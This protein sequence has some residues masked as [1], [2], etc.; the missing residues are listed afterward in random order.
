MTAIPERLVVYV[1]EQLDLPAT[2]FAQYGEREK[3]PYDHLEEICRQY[4]YRLCSQSDVMLL[5][6]YLLPF[7]ME[8]EEALPKD[9][10]KAYVFW[11][12]AAMVWIRQD[13]LIAPPILTL[14]RLVWRVQRIA[15]RRIYRRLT[16]ALSP[17]QKQALDDLLIVDATKAN[18]TPLAW[19]RIPAKKPSPESMYHLLERITYLSDLQLPAP[20]DNVHLGRFRQLAKRRRLCRRLFVD[21]ATEHSRWLNLKN[22][23]SV[24]PCWSLI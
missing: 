5:T 8:S 7:A 9:A 1:A 10:G 24:T 21:A 11:V 20:P 2:A 22:H 6:R 18:R 17:A 15:S 23:L 19:L 13:A 3:T 4:G 16:Q 12:D 14:E